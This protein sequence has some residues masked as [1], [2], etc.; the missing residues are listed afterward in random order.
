MICFF[1][2]P[3]D[4]EV[5]SHQQNVLCPRKSPTS[6]EK[7][8][9]PAITVSLPSS[10]WAWEWLSKQGWFT[11]YLVLHIPS[12]IPESSLFLLLPTLWMWNWCPHPQSWLFFQA[13]KLKFEKG[14]SQD[15]GRWD[16]HFFGCSEFQTL[17][18]AQQRG[19]LGWSQ[20]G[21]GENH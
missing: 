4:L 6:E 15:G 20:S 21:E 10:I 3:R 11:L 1:P 8:Q 7:L 16:L 14:Q 5:L 13:G 2:P 17:A 19:D 18:K 9:S 12:K